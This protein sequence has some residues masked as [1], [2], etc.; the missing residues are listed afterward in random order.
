M[1]FSNFL[2]NV[3]D[4]M[5]DMKTAALK[6]KNKEFLNAAMAGSALI[7]LAD[8][9][10]SAAEKQKMVKFIESHEALSIFTT[11]DV[12]KAFQDFVSQIEFDKD[13]GDA[14]A[15]EAIRKLKSN[16]EAARL[17]MRM[18]LSIAASDG[19][20]DDDEKMVARKVAQELNLNASEFEL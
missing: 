9:E 5:S 3:K 18:I 7:A 4:K 14:K 12:I 8:G 16:D 2:N 13:I 6:F 19:N 15:Y 10:I 17:V 1:S 20:F 11:S